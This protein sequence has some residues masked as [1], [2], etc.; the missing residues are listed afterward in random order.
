MSFD[1]KSQSKHGDT[2]GGK[3]GKRR[4]Q[5]VVD[6]VQDEIPKT[7]IVHPKPSSKR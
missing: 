4:R 3:Q 1:Q 5:K 6:C 2:S 7:L